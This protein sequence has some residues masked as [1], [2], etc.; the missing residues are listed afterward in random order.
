METVGREAVELM[1]PI[2]DALRDGPMRCE[3]VF[4]EVGAP[5]NLFDEALGRLIQWKAVTA[6]YGPGIVL[7][8]G[9]HAGGT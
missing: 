3:D 5:V 1:S 9:P 8:L 4:V 7:A 6:I 2:V